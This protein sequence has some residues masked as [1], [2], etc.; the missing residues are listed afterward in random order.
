[1]DKTLYNIDQGDI[2]LVKVRES[3]FNGEQ[4][5]HSFRWLNDGKNEL[6]TG[7]RVGRSRDGVRP[8]GI[9]DM[10]SVILKQVD[11]GRADVRVQARRCSGG[12]DLPRWVARRELI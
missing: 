12:S 5:K 6:F 7:K 8:A 11:Q 2:V 9:E 10:I 4:D 1:M 3:E